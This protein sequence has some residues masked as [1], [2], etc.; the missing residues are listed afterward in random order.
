MYQ[1]EYLRP[2]T[3]AEASALLRNRDDAQMLAGGQ[4]L[5]PV[6]K[7]RLA[8]PGAL[9][10]L[11]GVPKL[12]LIAADAAS[13][14]IGALA[15][16][17]VVA[18]SLLVRRALPAIADLADGIGDPQV[19][20]RGT[21]GGSIANNDPVADYP[22]ALVALGATVHTSEREIAANDFFTG[23]FETDL[24]SGEIVT[25]VRFPIP[26][27]AAYVKFPN[28]ASRFAIVGVFVALTDGVAR[29]AVTGAA[30]CVFRWTEAEQRLSRSFTSAA[31]D[32]L[33]MRGA[34]LN[35][36]LHAD[37]AYRAHLV[38]VMTRRSVRKALS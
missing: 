3:L 6:M 34:R 17:A 22:A 12:D 8:S 25:R 7:Q 15:T 9:V 20:N 18:A 10:D 2:S 27:R 4:T 33:A 19:R 1:F 29:V 11:K 5:I 24:V 26:Q 28:P 13:L 21:L 38:A 30:P 37:P 36:D 31:L 35:S 23:Q 14:E 32:G 16:H